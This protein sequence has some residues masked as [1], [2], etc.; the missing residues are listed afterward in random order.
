MSLIAPKFDD[1]GNMSYEEAFAELEKTINEL[2][3][4]D[5]PL[6]KVLSLYERGKALTEYCSKM[7]DKA[8]LQVRQLSGEG[9]TDFQFEE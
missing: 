4:G 8:E 3:G 1:I 9:I 6:E 2:D 7:L 5:L